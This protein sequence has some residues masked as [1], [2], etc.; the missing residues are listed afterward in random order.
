MWGND[1]RGAPDPAQPRVPGQAWRRAPKKALDAPEV[2][3]E[4]DDA[5]A[6][7][8]PPDVEAMGEGRSAFVTGTRDVSDPAEMRARARLLLREFLRATPRSEGEATLAFVRPDGTQRVMTRAELS[9]AV[10]RLRPRMRQIIRLAVE[11]RWP[12]QR[13]CEYLQISIKTYERDHVEA[14]DAIVEM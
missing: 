5:E 10:D 8:E 12:R 6:H 13:V 4:T 7:G 2:A 3:E 9:A 11:E 14:L 1:G